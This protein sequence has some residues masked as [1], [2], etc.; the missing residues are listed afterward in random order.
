MLTVALI[1]NTGEDE[2]H[3]SPESGNRDEGYSTMSSDIQG[4]GETSDLSKRELEDLKEASDE[5][6][7]ILDTNREVTSIVVV[8]DAASDPDMYFI[9]LNLSVSINPRHSYPPNKDFLPFQHAMRSF[10]DSHLF[11]KFTATTSIPSPLSPS[12]F[13]VDIVDKNHPLRR[14]KGTSSLL[15]S[16]REDFEDTCSNAGSWCSGVVEGCWWDAEYVQHWLRLDDNRL[17]EQQQEEEKE[18]L[19]LEYDQTEI[20]EWSMSLSCEDVAKTSDVDTTKSRKNLNDIPEN[21]LLVRA[22][23]DATEWNHCDSNNLI[24]NTKREESNWSY[25][26]NNMD[27][28]LAWQETSP[29]G[30]W[31]SVNTNNSEECCQS[32]NDA[33]FNGSEKE[34]EEDGVDSKRSSIISEDAAEESSAV[35]TDFTRDFYRLVKFE[36]TKS[37]AS[38]SS[39]SNTNCQTNTNDKKQ[40][41]YIQ[42]REMALQ[43]V[44]SFIAEQQRYCHKREVEDDDDVDVAVDDDDPRLS[45]VKSPS[46]ETIKKTMECHSSSSTTNQDCLRDVSDDEKVIE[47]NIQELKSQKLYST[48]DY[49]DIDGL[50]VGQSCENNVSCSNVERDSNLLVNNSESGY[51][52]SM[53]NKRTSFGLQKQRHRSLEK[54]ET[55]TKVPVRNTRSASLTS[56][57]SKNDKIPRLENLINKSLVIKKSRQSNFHDNVQNVE[58]HKTPSSIGIKN[59]SPQKISSQKNSMKSRIPSQIPSPG[60]KQR[61]TGIPILIKPDRNLGNVKKTS[62]KPTITNSKMKGT[63]IPIILSK[64]QQTECKTITKQPRRQQQQQQQQEIHTK[65]KDNRSKNHES[66]IPVLNERRSDL[67]ITTRKSLETSNEPEIGKPVIIRGT[68]CFNDKATSKDVIE[69]LNKMI[70]KSDEITPNNNKSQGDIKPLDVSCC[71]PTGWVHVERGDIDFADPKVRYKIIITRQIFI[72]VDNVNKQKHFCLLLNFFIFLFLK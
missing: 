50:N 12:M 21:D 45:I 22:D 67:I 40:T 10:S 49:S 26:T 8:E 65:E 1:K 62:T 44:L 36:S 72:H 5:T 60:G 32:L 6:D 2:G 18:I 34:E 15:I 30:S 55:T 42:E 3:E 19:Q 39:K 54:Q 59:Q 71:C 57:T 66:N 35:G 31:S 20:E 56:N 9:P 25:D 41:G 63:K 17:K 61:E 7:V 4:P 33:Y 13:L 58:S 48:D 64:K 27:E 11:L 51:K 14:T 24:I 46:D 53:E 43:S 28:N 37:L 69:E 52:K 38:N 68:C 23:D 70:R 29:G 47:I 16:N